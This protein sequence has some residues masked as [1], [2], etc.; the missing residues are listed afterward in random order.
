MDQ[1]RARTDDDIEES[2]ENDLAI[3]REQFAETGGQA[4]ENCNID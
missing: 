4:D 1:H 2:V 3:L